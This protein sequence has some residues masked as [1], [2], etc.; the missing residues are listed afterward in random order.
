MQKALSKNQLFLNKESIKSDYSV[1][2]EFSEHS[3]NE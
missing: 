1:G 2:D 3:S